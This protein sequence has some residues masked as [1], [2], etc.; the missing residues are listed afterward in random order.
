MDTK[1][2]AIIATLQK[3]TMQLKQYQSRVLDELGDFLTAL[4][5][6]RDYRDAR[7]NHADEIVRES[8]QDYNFV[9]KAWEASKGLGYFS[10]RDGL[11]NWLPDVYLK[12]P[13]GGG[14]T[15]LACHAIE[16][17]QQQYLRRQAGLILWIVPTTQIYR[18]TLEK[19][20]DRTHPYR[21]VLD[22]ASGG[23]TLIR[24][25]NKPLKPADLNGNMVVLMLMLPAANRQSKETLRMFRDA[26]GYDA[27]FPDSD[28]YAAHGE[29]LADMPNLHAF[30]EEGIFSPVVKSSL[31]NV[32]KLHRPLLIVDEGQKAYSANAR[33]TLCDF[34][35]AFVLELSATPP[36]DTSIV[37]AASGKELDNEEMIKL[38]IHL[39]NTPTADWHDTL[40][41]AIDKRAALEKAADRFYQNSSR[42]IRP[43]TLIQVERTGKDQRNRRHVHAEDV[44]EF[45]IAQSGIRPEHIAI[46][47]S[48]KDDIEGI[49]LLS[50]ECQ[51]RYI[52]TKAAL[53]EG[54]DCAFA[55]ILAVLTN[56][57]SETAMT[58]LVGRILRQPDAKK[59]KI[60]ALDE[61]YV[62]TRRG[63]ADKLINSIKQEL[64]NEGLGDLAG[65]LSGGGGGEPEPLIDAKIRAKFRKFDGRIYLPQFVIV[66]NGKVRLMDYSADILGNIKWDK[67]RFP[68][69]LKDVALGAGQG[70]TAVRINRPRAK[71]TPDREADEMTA[72]G[73]DA[74]PVFM[75]RQLVEVVPNAWRAHELSVKILDYFAKR[76]GPQ[77]TAANFIY[78]IEQSKQLLEKARDNL[79]FDTFSRL[80]HD[81]QLH[82]VLF[83]GTGGWCIPSKIKIHRRKKLVRGDHSQI[84][85]SLFDQVHEDDFNTLE[86]QVALYMDEQEKLLWWYRNR[87]R[88]DY[89][90]QGWKPG[91]IYPDFIAKKKGENTVAVIETKGLHLKNED[92]EYK[93][94]VF[95]MCSK[96]CRSLTVH[97]VIKNKTE[98]KKLNAE[99]EDKNFLFQVVYE[100]EWQNVLNK[101][102]S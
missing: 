46:K 9:E 101:I 23:R 61:C 2:F 88:L 29:L 34:N 72:G 21:Q 99:F 3:S 80:I 55:Y 74:E 59:T 6:K 38:D 50:E 1:L 54:W 28:D 57:H 8:A 62:F 22:I 17:I 19:L 15:L 56:P 45:L 60:A 32:I 4:A 27:F 96:M 13:T 40:I 44:K 36:R 92:T 67:I 73:L 87:A 12:V 70:V 78:I 35:P 48:E 75:T 41:A 53:Q 71:I 16:R 24:E 58:Q 93:K 102:F 39:R 63:T 64:E 82:F 84:E 18:Q 94:S 26:G 77:K 66:K 11:N 90:L 69:E 25:R 42:Y 52:I 33:K 49:D 14:K 79:A 81:K 31:G 76:D 85:R 20:A 30:A 95:D 5:D 98:W 100:D 51:V 7:L 47:S 97:D 83:T 91:K 10:Q 89:R 65:R 68:A 37:A 86:N 43:I